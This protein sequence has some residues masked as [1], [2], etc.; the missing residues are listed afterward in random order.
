MQELAVEFMAEG[1]GADLEH[2]RA[3][4][5]RETGP[6]TPKV[7]VRAAVFHDDEILLVKEPED[8]LWSPPGGWADVGESPAEAIVREI[9][10]ESGYNVRAVKFIALYDRDRHGHPLSPTTSTS[11]SSPAQVKRFFEHYHQPEL[12]AD[13]D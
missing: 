2:L 7:D 9:H 1:S 10:E 4:F 13:F 11:W 8:G 6:A 5:A 12:P 3:L